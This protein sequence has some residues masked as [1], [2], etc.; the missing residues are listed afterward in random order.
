MIALLTFKEIGNVKPKFLFAVNLFVAALFLLSSCCET[1]ECDQWRATE[2]TAINFTQREL[3]EFS[4]RKY[5]L[6]SNFT[7][8]ID[9]MW[10][11]RTYY[12]LIDDGTATIKIKFDNTSLFQFP[13]EAGYDYE[14]LFLN[15]STKVRIAEINDIQSDQRFCFTGFATNTCYNKLISLKIDGVVSTSFT[16]KK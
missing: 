12:S 3:V 10:L 13:I 16:L 1:V 8:A 4:V 9:S 14:L 5:N 6:N 11:N 15:G 2:I 7:N